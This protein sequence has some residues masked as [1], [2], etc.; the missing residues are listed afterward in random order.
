MKP[1]Q[2]QTPNHRDCEAVHRLIP[3]YSMEATDAEE[4]RLVEVHLKN[5]P[6][7]AAELQEYRALA[8]KMLYSAPL[9]QAPPHL[10]EQLMASIQQQIVQHDPAPDVRLTGR[11]NFS[12]RLKGAFGT[13]VRSYSFAFT[14][15]AV[16]LLLLSNLYSFRQIEELR[17]SQEQMSGL[18]DG[19]TS[20]LA[21]IGAGKTQRIELQSVKG[22]DSRAV[23]LCNPDE[24]VGFVYTEDFPA[25]PSGN[26]YQVWLV[27]EDQRRVNAGVFQVNPEG[28]GT[29]IFQFSEP[30]GNFE[31]VEIT[32][33]L[34]PGSLQ[35]SSA[36]MMQ[37]LLSY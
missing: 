13:K 5:C 32:R 23:M 34:D 22:T 16:I 11:E 30:L 27:R 35:P 31:A 19:H 7:A 6:E 24:D 37:G 28:E 25:L 20:V 12:T 21:L 29:L 2:R 3:A 17:H 9:K 8:H 18:L 15:L 1:V 36:L 14:G 33:E 10:G 4:T 26:V